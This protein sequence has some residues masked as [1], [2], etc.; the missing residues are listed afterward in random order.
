[1]YKL[2]EIIGQLSHTLA[3]YYGMAI[4]TQSLSLRLRHGMSYEMH[5]GWEWSE[6][7]RVD[8]FFLYYTADKIIKSETLVYR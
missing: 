2:R 3:I 8:T 7:N 6:V 1:M 5:P 4:P